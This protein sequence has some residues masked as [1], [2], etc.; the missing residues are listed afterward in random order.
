MRY[1]KEEDIV[2]VVY[3]TMLR[4]K[5]EIQIIQGRFKTTDSYS[6]AGSGF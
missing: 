2:G 6:Q 4:K 5:Y 3:S 1:K